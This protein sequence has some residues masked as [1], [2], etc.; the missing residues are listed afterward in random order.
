MLQISIP[1]ELTRETTLGGLRQFIENKFVI[2][3]RVFAPFGSKDGKVYMMEIREDYER[4][5]WR[6]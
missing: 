5:S 1:D 4:N 2:C 6:A 3:G